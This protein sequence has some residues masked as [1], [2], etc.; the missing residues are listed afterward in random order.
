MGFFLVLYS[1]N[2]RFRSVWRNLVPQV[3]DLALFKRRK[4]CSKKK[5][6]FIEKYVLFEENKRFEPVCLYILSSTLKKVKSS[7]GFF[8]ILNVFSLIPFFL[9]SSFFFRLQNFFPFAC[10]LFSR[11]SCFFSRLTLFFFR[12][13]FDPVKPW[14][15][16]LQPRGTWC[17]EWQ[18][19]P[20]RL[21]SP[22]SPSPPWRHQPAP[23]PNC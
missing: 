17:H 9:C 22:R 23:V 2:V 13:S 11:L 16:G 10:V 19:A 14:G 20:S 1:S 5:V 21:P 3:K 4:F 15:R 7:K 18:A 8:F 12:L 6:L